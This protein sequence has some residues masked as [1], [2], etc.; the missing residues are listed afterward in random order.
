MTIAQKIL[1]NGLIAAVGLVSFGTSA[2][3]AAKTNFAND[4][5]VTKTATKTLPK[6]TRVQVVYTKTKN[7]KQYA[8]IEASRL[9]YKLQKRVG[10]S[11]IATVATTNLRKVSTQA[12]D[13]LNVLFKGASRTTDKKDTNAHKLKITTD[14]YIQYFANSVTKAP[15]SST[16][17]TASRSKGSIIYLYS[18]TSMTKLPDKH[19]RKSG[20]YQYRLAIRNNHRQSE[21]S[22]SYSVGSLK[23]LFYVPTL[24]A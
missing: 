10:S 12:S 4:Y 2:Q 15:V 9:S 7:G 6:G 17:I 21:L 14:G 24:K 5:V 20:N 1:L 11:K 19:I 18:K 8:T 13:K 23:N 3:A 22:Q 16:K